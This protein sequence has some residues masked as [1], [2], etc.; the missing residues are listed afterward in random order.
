MA[1]S[2]FASLSKS[3]M[4]ASVHTVDAFVFL[5]RG[6]PGSGS[7]HAASAPCENVAAAPAMDTQE[8]RPKKCL[9]EVR[10][11]IESS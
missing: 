1:P 4:S 10:T 9:D 2:T 11:D 3:V 6:S 8:R 5:Y 7:G